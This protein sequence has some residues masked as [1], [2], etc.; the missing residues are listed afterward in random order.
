MVGATVLLLATASVARAESGTCFA[1]AEIVEVFAGAP[2]CPDAQY[3]MLGI[4]SPR[5]WWYGD[6]ISLSIQDSCGAFGQALVSFPAPDAGVEYVLV[7]TPEA[8]AAFGVQF[9]RVDAAVTID[10]WGGAIWS[11]C[12]GLWFSSPGF[13]WPVGMAMRQ[14]ASG[15]LVFSAP[16]PTNA[17]GEVGRFNG[18]LGDAGTGDAASAPW[19]PPRPVCPPIEPPPVVPP[20][21][22]P[23]TPPTK[24]PG[25][26]VLDAGRDPGDADT[27]KTSVRD[28][29]PPSIPTP[30]TAPP[31]LVVPKTD[32]SS[33]LGESSLKRVEGVSSSSGCALARV[34]STNG[35]LGPCA[36]FGSL[37]FGSLR[38]RRGNKRP[39][40]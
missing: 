24:P 11:F 1:V 36:L 33:G 5:P 25:A 2:G 10:P 39:R 30:S 20:K 23:V 21:E 6:P 22:P 13:T 37:L 26:P 38:R 16:A 3:L 19:P 34:P 4:P 31:P 27:P 15:S 29:R 40:T 8:E 9:D 7:G 17:R 18:C 35:R 12:S 32:A 14:D 28:A